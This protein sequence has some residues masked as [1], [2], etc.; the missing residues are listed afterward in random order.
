MPQLVDLSDIRALILI[1][2]WQGISTGEG[3]LY[4]NRRPVFSVYPLQYVRAAHRNV[5]T[6]QAAKKV[7]ASEDDLFE[8]FDRLEAFFQRLEIYTEMALDRRMVD[9]VAK[10]MAETLNILAIATNEISQGRI[11]EPVAVEMRC[12]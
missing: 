9:T 6:S 5:I 8:I 7:R 3:H 4:C 11:S 12:S 2:H 1:R 10:I